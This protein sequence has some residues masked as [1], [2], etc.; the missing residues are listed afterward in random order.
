MIEP[1]D[2]RYLTW[3]YARIGSLRQANAVYTH[4][5]LLRLLFTREF[6]WLIPNDVNRVEDG[7]YIRYEFLEDSGLTP[8]VDPNWLGLGC[9]VLEMIVSVSDRLA[10]EA[11]RDTHYWFW[12]LMDNLGLTY[13]NDGTFDERL[14]DDIVHAMVFRDFAPDG[15]G[16]LFPLQ[17]PAE[18][19]RS[20][21][22]WH[23][24]QNYVMEHV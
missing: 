3:L 13:F 4:W 5:S 17:R 9:S 23:Q 16:S 1:L 10:F 14:V 20:I 22:I 6:A 15:R 18:D 24:L 2:E 19:Q 8:D 7:R 21:E 11:D 12:Q